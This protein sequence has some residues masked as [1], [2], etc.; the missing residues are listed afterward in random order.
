MLRILP[1]TRCSFSSKVRSSSIPALRA[2]SSN[3]Q[4]VDNPDM[5][6]VGFSLAEGAILLARAICQAGLTK[7]NGEGRRAIDQGG[8]KLNGEKISDTNLELAS[9]GEYIVQIGR[10]RFARIVVL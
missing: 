3:S 4:A 7:S 6:Q 1:P 2:L 5:P 10:R 9:A 8:V